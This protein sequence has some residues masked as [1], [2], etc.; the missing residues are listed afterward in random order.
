[1]SHNHIIPLLEKVKSIQFNTDKWTLPE[2]ITNI[3][4]D[5]KNVT[6]ATFNTVEYNLKIIKLISSKSN[7]SNLPGGRISVEQ[8][9]S[10]SI[11]QIFLLFAF[12][13]HN[14]RTHWVWS[15]TYFPILLNT[16]LC[17]SLSFLFKEENKKTQNL[18]GLPLL[19]NDLIFEEFTTKSI[20]MLKRFIFLYNEHPV[21]SDFPQ[22]DAQHY[23]PHVSDDN[24][25]N[26]NFSKSEMYHK[27]RPKPTPHLEPERFLTIFDH[28]IDSLMIQSDTLAIISSTLIELNKIMRDKEIGKLIS[29]C[30][31]VQKW[32]HEGFER[33]S[34]G[35]K[36]HGVFWVLD[37]IKQSCSRIYN[38]PDIF[39]PNNSVNIL[40]LKSDLSFFLSN[41]KTTPL[42]FL[43]TAPCHIPASHRYAL[44]GGRWNSTRISGVLK[45]LAS[46]ST[47]S[48]PW[49]TAK[50]PTARLSKYGANAALAVVRRSYAFR[51]GVF[52][53]MPRT[54][55]ASLKTPEM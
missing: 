29:D 48:I 3:D 37:R 55:S 1:M 35:Q 15:A 47:A 10:V 43:D 33:D 22:D 17:F 44:A 21:G 28:I 46:R 39:D 11:Y 2:T 6:F 12:V 20:E 34:R 13:F 25:I 51:A 40:N 52:L 50:S 45:T 24:G 31:K 23:I 26:R 41:M 36:Y 8:I 14:Y 18:K 7:Q 38:S 32:T 4:A 9:R 30:K 53:V 54:H 49:N 42:L 5:L 27:D 16:T 19:T